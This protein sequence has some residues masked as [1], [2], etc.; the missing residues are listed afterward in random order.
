[1]PYLYLLFLVCGVDQAVK[2]WV[3]A[4]MIPLQSFVLI[5]GLVSVTYVL[6]YGAAFGI[7]YAKT[8]LLLAITAGTFVYAW[9]HRHE[10][11]KYPQMFQIGIA[12]AL[13]GALGNFL[14]RVRLGY[15]VDFLDFYVWPVF[16]IA[17]IA[18]VIG[19]GLVVAGLVRQEMQLKKEQAQPEETGKAVSREDN[20]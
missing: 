16:N 7:M 3:M 18:I 6:N 1:M 9:I 10:V 20:S 17:D 13:G 14:D 8:Y 11:S 12:V 2:F 4:Q 5:P 19:V 15:V